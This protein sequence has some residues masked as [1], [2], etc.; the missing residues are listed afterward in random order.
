MIIRNITIKNFRSYYG[1]ST[2]EIGDTLTLI[3][4]SNGDG[5]STF[6]DAISWLLATDGK[7]IADLKLI[8]KKRASELS[9]GDSDEVYVSMT[10]ENEQGE[11]TVVKSFRFTKSMGDR[12][13]ASNATFTLTKQVGYS[14]QDVSGMYIENDF[15]TVVRQFSMFKGETQLNVF[16]SSDSLKLILNTFSDVKGFE[17]YIKYL[18]DATSKATTAAERARSKDRT[19]A[20][21]TEEL[22]NK[23]RDLERTIQS[24]EEEL[25]DKEKNSADLTIQ[26][27]NIEESRESSE[28]LM[29]VNRRIDSLNSRKASYYAD[30]K[31]N[32]TARLLDEMWVL[33]GYAPIAQEYI[34]KVHTLDIAKRKMN[35]EHQQQVGA[36]KLAKKIELGY[37]PLAVNVPDQKT[38]EELLEDEVCKVCGRP[39][40]KGSEPWLF[41]KNKLEEFLRSLNEDSE[42]EEE[43]PK[44]VRQYIEELANRGITLNNNLART[45][46]TM[47]QTVD[48]AIGHNDKMHEEISR[49]DASLREA[50]AEKARILHGQEGMTEAELISAGNNISNML[51]MKE[52]ADRRIAQIKQ[53]L[54]EIK[55]ERAELVKKLRGMSASSEAVQLENLSD[56]YSLVSDAFKEAK[57]TNKKN[58]LTKIEDMANDYLRLLNIGDFK[59]R[60][61]IMEPSQDTAVAQLVDADKMEVTNPNTALLTTQYMAILFAISALSIDKNETEYPLFFDAPTSSFTE[62]KEMEF[63]GILSGMK[64]QMIVVTKS[65]LKDR[66]NG[67]S[68][69]D[70]DRIKSING[71]V[72]RIEKKRPF[73][74]ENL[75]TIQTVVSKIK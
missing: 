17:P 29:S 62:A 33:M 3:I 18:D 26:L 1:A 12:I 31:E 27:K 6:Y 32:Y 45:V 5:K 63:F 49:I 55:E 50:M 53:K 48:K 70:T 61:R 75:S 40:P 59:G 16:K 72:Y 34:D 30:I 38:M 15:P 54:P 56:F 14:K 71:M 9:V 46:T 57:L 24:L 21:K 64:K 11:K 60:I 7:Q 25:R 58:L 4:G 8:S 36:R 73:D 13:S 51:T 39:A 65:F 74:D 23:I 47:G 10:Y 52:H 28:L 20:R 2:F 42:G 19:N 22:S 66:G 35:N 67:E 69:L 41:M 37:V 44:F 68:I 43:D